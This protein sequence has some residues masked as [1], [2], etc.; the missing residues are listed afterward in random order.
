M[1]IKVCG[2]TDQEAAERLLSLRIDMLGL[3]FVNTSPRCVSIEKALNIK[4][5]VRGSIKIV[6]VFQDQPLTEVKQIVN[7]LKPDYVQLH[8]QEN[9]GFC[10]EIPVPVIKAI[11]LQ[12]SIRKT[13]QL[14][15]EYKNVCT[16]F[17]IDRKM[18]GDGPLVNLAQFSELST[19]YPLIFSGGLSPDNISQVLSSVDDSLAGVDVSS[20]VEDSPG[21]KNKKKISNFVEKVRSCCV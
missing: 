7:R 12:E 15:N 5:I 13:K 10:E 16:Y 6:A 17:L 2:I 19:Y 1:L 8:G 14:L 9:P 20:G 4:K 18:Q 3:V 21:Q 11:R